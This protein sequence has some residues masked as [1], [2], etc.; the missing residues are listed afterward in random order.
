MPEAGLEAPPISS[1]E[2]IL[3]PV[4]ILASRLKFFQ[5]KWETITADAVILDWVFGVRTPFDDEVFQNSPPR[6]PVWSSTEMSKMSEKIEK[7]LSK[8]AIEECES[9]KEEFISRIFHF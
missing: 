2:A 6:E 9:S 8:A 3:D 4:S 1:E 7:L 5:E